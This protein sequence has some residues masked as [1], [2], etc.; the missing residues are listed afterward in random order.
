[1]NDNDW[2]DIPG[3][4]NYDAHRAGRVRNKTTGYILRSQSRQHTY[5]SLNLNGSM[6]FLHWLIAITFVP[7]D[8]PLHKTQVDH[9]NDQPRDNAAVNLQWLTPTDNVNKAIARG[10]IDGKSATR[11]IKVTYRD[12]SDQC[13][14]S[15]KQCVE[16]INISKGIIHDCI[17]LYSGYLY[18]NDDDDEEWVCKFEFIVPKFEDTIVK[19][20]VTEKGYDHLTA[21]SNGTLVNTKTGKEVFGSFTGRYHLIKANTDLEGKCQFKHRLLAKVFIPNPDNLPGINHK[22]GVKTNYAISNLEWGTQ[23]ENV[24]HAVANGLIKYVKLLEPFDPIK[25]NEPNTVYSYSEPILKL[26]LNGKIIK[27]YINAAEAAK[28]LG[29]QEKFCINACIKYRNGITITSA[30]YGWCYKKDFKT[31]IVNSKLIDLFP[32]I[33]NFDIDYDVIRENV[34]CGSKHVWQIDLDGTRIKLWNSINIITREIGVPKTC[35]IASLRTEGLYSGYQ[36]KYATLDE[37]YNPSQQYDKKINKTV[38]KALGIPDNKIKFKLGILE[39][40]RL[41]LI[42]DGSLK[43][44]TP[45]AQLNDDGTI[46]KIWPSPYIIEKVLD[47]KTTT[48]RYACEIKNKWRKLTLDEICE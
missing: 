32:E 14:E 28:E 19:Q 24:E 11:P 13:F 37:T 7:N 44:T 21:Y 20:E 45:I 31:P 29:M 5:I 41:N 3:F 36:W 25:H 46:K 43:I 42:K 6:Y 33:S 15:L 8:D 16:E 18:D 38:K 39:I 12:G 2:K 27:E 9:I 47:I 34:L 48:I 30:G 1:M 23:Q 17:E 10:R 35:I 4:D 26:E 40:L 22:D